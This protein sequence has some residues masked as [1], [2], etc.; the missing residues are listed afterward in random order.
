MRKDR[1]SLNA[2]MLGLVQFR[3]SGPPVV[4]CNLSI[5]IRLRFRRPLVPLFIEAN[6][7][8][9]ADLKGARGFQSF[10][11]LW[12]PS[13]RLK[14]DSRKM[15]RCVDPQPIG[16]SMEPPVIGPR[17]GSVKKTGHSIWKRVPIPR[18]VLDP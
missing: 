7:A 15:E 3:C 2:R 10:V 18:E 1:L 14:R 16:G 4:S 9:F 6:R 12:L 5:S 13:Q 11:S 8:K 17:A